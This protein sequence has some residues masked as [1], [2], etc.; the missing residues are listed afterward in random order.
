MLKEK[1]R[2]IV[3]FALYAPYK[4]CYN[5]LWNGE[6]RICY[7]VGAT[8]NV[9]AVGVLVTVK[10]WRWGGGYGGDALPGG[11]STKMLSAVMRNTVGFFVIHTIRCSHGSNK[12]ELERDVR[13]Y[14][15]KRA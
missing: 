12:M 6:R 4:F 15:N 8:M 3:A 9:D 11:R 5:I 7:S 10:W 14:T 2:R 1:R 13:I